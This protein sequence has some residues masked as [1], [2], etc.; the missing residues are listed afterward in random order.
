MSAAHAHTGI[1][2]DIIVIGER[3]HRQKPVCRAV[4]KIDEGTGPGDAGDNAFDYGPRPVGEQRRGKSVDG[5][6]FGGGGTAFRLGD[7]L[8]DINQI[9]G[10]SA[11]KPVMRRAAG[12]QHVDQGAM[13]KKI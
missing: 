3:A 1:V 12:G 13:D 8:A 7:M 4:F 2:D 5:A 6:A 10:A 11:A 9:G